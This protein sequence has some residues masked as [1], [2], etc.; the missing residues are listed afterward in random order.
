MCVCIACGVCMLYV[1]IS[2]WHVLCVCVACTYVYRCMFP[3]QGIKTESNRSQRK[4]QNAFLCHSPSLIALR[5]GL[6]LSQK[7]P[8]LARLSD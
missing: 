2:V 3:F 7:L 8:I 1:C 6:L 5:H 4:T